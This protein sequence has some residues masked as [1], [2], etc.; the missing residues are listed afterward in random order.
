[1]PKFYY[2]QCF[3]MNL[4]VEVKQ[5]SLI[6]QEKNINVIKIFNAAEKT[7][8]NYKRLLKRIKENNE[9]ILNLPNLK[10]VTAKVKSNKD[11]NGVPKY[12]GHKLMNYSW[13]VHQLLDVASYIVESFLDSSN[14]MVTCLMARTG[15][16]WMSTQTKEITFYSMLL[17][18]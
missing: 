18:F 11:N 13:K 5:F 4:L 16:T 9:Y 10:I 15:L 12:Q 3:F 1:M 7:K 14:N 2:R 6:T 8:S 17:A